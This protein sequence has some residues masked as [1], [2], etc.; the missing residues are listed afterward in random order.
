VPSRLYLGISL[1]LWRLELMD[2]VDEV[3]GDIVAVFADDHR[4]RDAL[5]RQICELGVGICVQLSS[6]TKSSGV[7]ATRIE[8]NSP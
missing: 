3:V 7:T 5:A 4:I 2:R 8:R 1:V 6:S